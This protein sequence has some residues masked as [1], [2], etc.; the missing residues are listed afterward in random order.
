MS[1]LGRIGQMDWPLSALEPRMDVIVIKV[2]AIG[3]FIDEARLS[4]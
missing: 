4:K 1:C 2:A 3:V